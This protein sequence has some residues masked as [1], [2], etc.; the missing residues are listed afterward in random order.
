PL[1]GSAADIMKIAM[2]DIAPRLAE[3]SGGAR[4]LL[5]VHDELV[6]EVPEQDM[7]DVS[8]LTKQMMEEAWELSVP[9]SVDIKAGRNW[10]DLAEVS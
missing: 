10:R 9:L 1:Q 6:F 5:Q 3:A 4:M 2:A 8:K 7:S